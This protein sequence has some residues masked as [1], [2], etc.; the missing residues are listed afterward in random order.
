[1]VLFNFW[2]NVVL[3]LPQFFYAISYTNFSGVTLYEPY[4]YQL[5]NVVYTSLPIMI[6]AIYDKELEESDFI[7]NPKYYSTGIK[8][9]YFNFQVFLMYYFKGICQALL[10]CYIVSLMD[11][12]PQS[13]GTFLGFWGFGVTV[14]Y[15]TQ[16]MSTLK[17]FILTNSFSL[18][19]VLV[20]LSSF[21]AFIL[22][23]LVISK[24]L[25][26]NVHF[27]MFNT[28]FSLG[29]FW[30]V[31]VLI[32]ILC[33]FLDYLW[34]LVQKILFLKY[35][36]I[37]VP[38]ENEEKFMP[39]KNSLERVPLQ[40]ITSININQ[41]IKVENFTSEVQFLSQEP[42]KDNIEDFKKSFL[43]Q[44][45]QETTIKQKIPRK[46]KKKSKKKPS[47]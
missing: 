44:I 47:N 22:S 17:I 30:V 38:R 31:H 13:D 10:L 14:F 6:Y 23:F 9:L 26:S 45:N 28:L 8:R 25:P 1:M 20:T 29:S 21:L 32:F 37:E 27:E 19:V 12:A 7:N 16:L 2:K 35:I 46:K 42:K 39:E 15:F 33:I 11:L 41:D 36:N 18:L 40:E 3:V 5:V 4:M 43:E 24:L 34:Y